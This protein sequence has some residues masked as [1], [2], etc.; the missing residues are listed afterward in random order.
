MF[1]SAMLSVNIAVLFL[2]KPFEPLNAGHARGSSSVVSASVK[3]SYS[4]EASA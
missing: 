1:L 4:F 3:F 2:F